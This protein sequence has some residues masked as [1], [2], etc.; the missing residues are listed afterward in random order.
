MEK[1]YAFFRKWRIIADIH[2]NADGGNGKMEG[3]RIFTPGYLR[4]SGEYFPVPVYFESTGW[5]LGSNGIWAGLQAI[6]IVLLLVLGAGSNP[7]F[8]Q[9]VTRGSFFTQLLLAALPAA[10][11]ILLFV[12]GGLDLSMGAVCIITTAVAAK[13][14]E[15]G[16]P[17]GAACLYGLSVAALF[18]VVNGVL[19]GVARVPGILVTLAA[20]TLARGRA[21]TLL[22]GRTIVVASD[23]PLA[24]PAG[25]IFLLLLL[26]AAFLWIQ[27][28]GFNARL[29]KNEA[30]AARALRVGAPYLVSALAAGMTGLVYLGY[31]KAATM[32]LGSNMEMDTIV[33]M[34]LSGAC[35]FGL[36]GNVL[37]VL[38]AACTMTLARTLM[39][40]L[41][42]SIFLQY[43][44]IGAIGLHGFGYLYLYHWIAGLIHRSDSARKEGPASSSSVG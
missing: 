1:S 6:G 30:G 2:P 31:I 16:M 4:S 38:L 42:F 21:L 22:E 27:L 41:N 43:V 37:G 23:M 15:A 10:A 35:M 24:A 3:R 25:W 5:R 26:A 19:A 18:G 12:N 17:S 44:A 11:M 39:N 14:M 34:A 8:F 33:I 40:I 32:S 20:G 9:A 13:A 29:A 7:Y 28:P 36:Y